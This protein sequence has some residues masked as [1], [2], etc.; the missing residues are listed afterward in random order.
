MERHYVKEIVL[1][2]PVVEE[3]EGAQELKKW[4]SARGRGKRGG[5]TTK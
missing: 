5:T 1:I 4:T 2:V 3:K